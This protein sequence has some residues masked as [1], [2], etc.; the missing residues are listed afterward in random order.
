[1]LH[2]F[3]RSVMHGVIVTGLFNVMHESCMPDHVWYLA[4]VNPHICHL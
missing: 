2:G 4:Y 1:M 3:W